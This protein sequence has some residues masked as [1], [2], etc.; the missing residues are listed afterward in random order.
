MENLPY[1][2]SQTQPHRAKERIQRILEKF[3]V[4]EI[5]L[6]ENFKRFEVRLSFIYEAI[7]VSI[8]V[9]YAKLGE[10]YAGGKAWERLSDADKK[11]AKNAAYAAMEDY[12]K[13]MLTMHKLSIMSLQEIFLPNLVGRDGIRLA[14]VMQNHL[15]EFLEGKLL[16]Q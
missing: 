3:G 6:S 4:D 16:T 2:N 13:A 7:P 14:E 9:N 1:K 15:P 11:K 8:P 10:L 12:L 5:N